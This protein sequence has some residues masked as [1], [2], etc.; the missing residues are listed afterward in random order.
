MTHFAT[1]LAAASVAGPIMQ[2]VNTLLCLFIDF[3]EIWRKEILGALGFWF[4]CAVS[5][6]PEN[7]S[8]LIINFSLKN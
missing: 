2:P 1:T 5:S 4:S 3:S 6:D 8:Q 7:K